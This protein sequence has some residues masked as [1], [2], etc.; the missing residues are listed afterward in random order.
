[1]TTNKGRF[2]TG[3][4][5]AELLERYGIGAQ[6]EAALAAARWADDSHPQMPLRRP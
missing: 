4:S 1:M 2:R 3:L 5:L 6:C